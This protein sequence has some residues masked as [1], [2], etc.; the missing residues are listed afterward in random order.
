MRLPADWLKYI[1]FPSPYGDYGSYRLNLATGPLSSYPSFRP[2]A[3]IMVL[4]TTYTIDGEELQKRSFRPLTGIVVLIWYNVVNYG[5]QRYY[6]F[7]SP[8]GDYGSYPH[9][10]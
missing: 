2:L 8:C 7:P 10:L 1:P 5:L 9:P 3:G 6:M 4:I